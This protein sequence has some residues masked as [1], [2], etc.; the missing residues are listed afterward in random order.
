MINSCGWFKFGYDPVSIL[1]VWTKQ[2][3][4]VTSGSL[5]ADSG[6]VS[7]SY[8][9]PNLEKPIPVEIEIGDT[10]P[11][12]GRGVWYGFRID[13]NSI[14]DD[15]PDFISW[16]FI[17]D[18]LTDAITCWPE[19]LFPRDRIPDL[20]IQGGW[21]NGAWQ[22]N[23]VRT[24]AMWKGASFLES[25]S[26]VPDWHVGDT[27]LG[28]ERWEYVDCESPQSSATLDYECADP[29]F[30]PF[31]GIC[32]KVTGFQGKVPYLATLD[33]RSYIIPIEFTEPQ[34]GPD[35]D[36]T[37]PCATYIYLNE[38]IFFEFEIRMYQ[39]RLLFVYY[40][41]FRDLSVEP[42]YWPVDYS[43]VPVSPF[44]PRKPKD[45]FSNG[46]MLPY[47]VWRQC[48]DSI[49][50]AW[51]AWRR[52]PRQVLGDGRLEKSY[53]G[54][55]KPEYSEI[56]LPSFV[57]GYSAGIRNEDYRMTCIAPTCVSQI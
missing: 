8:F 30:V 45:I 55:V 34:T 9:A 35:G 44:S 25:M 5:L 27:S 18:F 11:S 16:K 42:N 57:G 10:S 43:C 31:L 52:P 50:N 29:N 24:F 1:H 54:G 51:S 13:Y 47:C 20:R 28:L 7:C 36:T 46:F 14:F 41:G 37:S 23:L 2:S 26:S 4:V 49:P 17:D 21:N 53:V 56:F 12:K 6:I 15:S 32:K 40:Y 48:I 38:K 19:Y 22:K 39:I 3:L 33:R